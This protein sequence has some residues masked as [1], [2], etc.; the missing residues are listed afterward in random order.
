[1]YKKDNFI[2]K[3]KRILGA[4]DGGL[5][6]SIMMAVYF[7]LSFIGGIILSIIT[8]PESVLYYACSPLFSLISIFLIV[9]YFKIKSGEEFKVFLSV[10]SSR[11][12]YFILAVILGVGMLL[13]FGFVN[14]LIS[15]LIVSIG[16]NVS[17]SNIPLNNV[18]QFIL[19]SVVF[20]VLPAIFEELFFRSFIL[21]VTFKGFN[22]ISAITLSAFLFCLYHASATQFVYQ[23]IYGITLGVLFYKSGSVICPIVL[24]FINNFAVLLLSYIKFEINFY[25]PLIILS[26]ILIIAVSYLVMFFYKKDRAKVEQNSAKVVDFILPY[27]IFG[28]LFCILVIVVNVVTV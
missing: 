14:G 25:H 20:A 23:F 19:Y 26:G 18:W 27:G 4:G 11:P 3:E 17:Q 24:H 21:G 5:A 6:F 16:G 12:I 9:W 7:I 2:E 10:K 22:K 15:D 8:E 28:I 1:M 13:G